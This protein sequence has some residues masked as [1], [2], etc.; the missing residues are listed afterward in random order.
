MDAT[1]CGELLIILGAATGREPS[2]AQAH[3][4]AF[5]LNDVPFAVGKEALRAA[6]QSPDSGYVTPQV[7]RKHAQ[8]LLRRLAADVRSAKLRGLV[9]ADWPE[10]SP[11]PDDVAARLAAEWAATNDLGELASGVTPAE[12]KE[13]GQ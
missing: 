11:L 5:A 12:R 10:R 2:A 9:A 4:W 8:P 1:E 3:G 6:L 13:L 7:I